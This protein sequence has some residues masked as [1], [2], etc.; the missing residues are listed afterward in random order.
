MKKLLS[1]TFV[2]LFSCSTAFAQH[3][4]S[5]LHNQETVSAYYILE[6]LLN[7]PGINN[8]EIKMLIVDFPPL[9]MS[10][11]HRHPCPTFGYVLEG[12]I[13]SV[14]KGKK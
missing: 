3:H 1:I 4:D 12:E 7:E 8:K 5:T 6:Q 14:F 11:P 13:E 2:F 10:E 9:C